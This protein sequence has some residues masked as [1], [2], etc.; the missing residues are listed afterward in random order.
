MKLTYICDRCGTLIGALQLDSHEMELF[1]LEPLTIDLREDIIRCSETGD[2]FYYSLCDDCV[3][4]MSLHESDL[5]YY[6]TQD[7]H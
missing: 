7:P 2:L 1:G 5:P 6:R 4:T 3:E